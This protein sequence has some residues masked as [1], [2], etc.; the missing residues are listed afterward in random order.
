MEGKEA[1]DWG[2]CLTGRSCHGKPVRMKDESS[3]RRLPIR[4]M[5]TIERAARYEPTISALSKPG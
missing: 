5:D 1:R 4:P 3:T 2:K